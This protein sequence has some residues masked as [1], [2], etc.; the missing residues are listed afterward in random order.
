M[1]QT[2]VNKLKLSGATAHEARAYCAHPSIRDHWALQCMSR[3]PDQGFSLKRDLQY[4]SSQASLT[5]IYRST[6]VGMKGRVDLAQL[7]NRTRAC[8][9]EARYATTQPRGIKHW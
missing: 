6:A 7:E 4:L 8:G 9:V 3:C 1:R 5:L 2:L